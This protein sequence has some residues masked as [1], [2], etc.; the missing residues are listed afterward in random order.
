MHFARS[1]IFKKHWYTRTDLDYVL[2][3]LVNPCRQSGYYMGHLFNAQQVCMFL[4]E[5]I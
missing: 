5:C 3:Q 4:E 1:K 2:G